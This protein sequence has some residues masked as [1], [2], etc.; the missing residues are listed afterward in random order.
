MQLFKIRITQLK[1]GE[2]MSKTAL[3]TGGSEGIGKAFA[4]RLAKEGYTVTVVARNEKKLKEVVG[5][6]GGQ[7]K[8]V[9]ADLATV[10]GQTKIE[11]IL[12]EGRF[13]LLV[14]NAGV[15]TQG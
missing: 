15:G 11:K 7:N 13:D 3:V 2:L 12:T 10:E 5:Q 9:V 1:T 6:L 8:F 14:N 4:E